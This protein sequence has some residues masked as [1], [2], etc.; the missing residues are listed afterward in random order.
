MD[1]RNIG[2][3]R[4][5]QY[6]ELLD[7]K[8]IKLIKHYFTP[9]L[10]FPT[11]EELSTLTLISHSWRLGDRYFKL[12]HKYYG[13]SKYWWIIAWHNLAPTEHHLSIGTTIEIPLP[14]DRVLKM[15]G[16]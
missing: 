2:V 9:S 4:T 11:A 12:A 5:V 8:N 7:K 14:L 15:F 6:Q 13:N 10:K 1:N 3:N 16:Y